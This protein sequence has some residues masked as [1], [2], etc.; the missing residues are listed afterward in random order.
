MIVI[1]SLGGWLVNTGDGPIPKSLLT[2]VCGVFL[3]EFVGEEGEWVFGR[4]H[5]FLE[6]GE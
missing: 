1:V 4:R 5:S 3:A 6:G 2:F